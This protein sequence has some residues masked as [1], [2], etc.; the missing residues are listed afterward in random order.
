[1]LLEC[2]NTCPA[3]PIALNFCMMPFVHLGGS[4][5]ATVASVFPPVFQVTCLM[6][7][8]HPIYP[9]PQA[10]Q[11]RDMEAYR[12][13]CRFFGAVDLDAADALEQLQIFWREACA[14]TPRMTE[15]TTTNPSSQL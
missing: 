13:L 14:F 2:C 1:M 8:K 5:L 7:A 3:S 4:I 11:R 12:K 9:K 6:R 15:D 10:E